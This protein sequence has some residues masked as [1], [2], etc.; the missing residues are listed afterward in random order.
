[1]IEFAKAITAQFRQVMPESHHE[2]NRSQVVTYPYLT[3]DFYS[4]ALE[5]NAEG[6]YIDVDI[7]DNAPS[8]MD[9]FQAEQALKDHFRER[10]ELTDELFIRFSFLRSMKVPTNDEN[11][12]RRNLQFYCKVDWRN[13]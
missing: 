10:R 4:E 5:R 13:K 3:Y 7:F 8:Y 6:F 12:K 9:I 1:M 2:K 11:I